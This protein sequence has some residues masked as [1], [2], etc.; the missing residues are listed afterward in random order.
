MLRS[1]LVPAAV[2]LVA[3][4]MEPG[5]DSQAQSECHRQ[6]VERLGCCPTCDAECRAAITDECAK[7]HDEP[8]LDAE[9]EVGTSDDGGEPDE[10]DEPV[11]PPTPQ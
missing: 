6:L 2:A 8:L 5:C 9:V 10:P 1:L 4:V 7:I 11:L 3:L